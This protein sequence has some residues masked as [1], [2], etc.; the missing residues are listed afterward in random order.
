MAN[1]L[2]I[3]TR[4]INLN[5]T[6]AT[7]YT[8]RLGS[9][10]VR[11]VDG[12]RS[13]SPAVNN[14]KVFSS[15][16]TFPSYESVAPAYNSTG[17]YITT[18]SITFDRPLSINTT[19]YNVLL[20]KKGSGSDTLVATIASTDSRI[21]KNNKTI[22]I[23]LRNLLEGSS[24]YYLAADSGIFIDM[25]KFPTPA[26]TEAIFKYSTA[27]GPQRVRISPLNGTTGTFETTASI[28]FDRNMFF[29]TQDLTRNITVKTS[30]GTDFL[31]FYSTS[32]GVSIVNTSL[33][34][35][36]LSKPMPEGE[37]YINYSDKFVR[38]QY[39][40]PAT[41][42]SN[43]STFR[44]KQTSISNMTSRRY[45]ANVPYQ[46]F[47]ATTPQVLD[48]DLN[49]SK[50]YTFTLN[51]NSG[52]F[53]S[54]NGVIT[55]TT[56]VYQGTK[57]E[58]NSEIP[59]VRFTRSEVERNNDITFNYTLTK[60]GTLLVNNTYD[61]VGIP[62][63]LASPLTLTISQPRIIDETIT[64][65]ASVSTAT[66]LNGTVEFKSDGVVIATAPINIA[67]VAST[68][69]A[70]A[71]TGT[72]AIFASFIE[73]TTNDGNRYETL[74]SVTQQI[75]VD[76]GQRLSTGTLVLSSLGRITAG[77]NST[78]LNASL[79]TST[80]FTG[81][82]SG[83]VSI[84][85]S[86]FKSVTSEI[87]TAKVVDFAPSTGDGFNN[88]FQPG[89]IQLETL[90]GF[91]FEF[92]EYFTLWFDLAKLLSD[93]NLQPQ[94]TT[95][96]ANDM[97]IT[98]VDTVN[99]RLYLFESSESTY[100][101]SDI[102]DDI[103]ES[104]D[105]LNLTNADLSIYF[106]LLNRGSFWEADIDADKIE[107]T[108]SYA[109]SST[110]QTYSPARKLTTSTFV[111]NTATYSLGSFASGEY[112]FYADWEGR[113][114][115]P[116][117][118]GQTSTTITQIILPK[119]RV[120]SRIS[121]KT[122]TFT[123]YNVDRSINTC[124]VGV[125]VANWFN[126]S[127]P[128]GTITLNDGATQ[129][130]STSTFNKYENIRVTPTSRTTS[131]TGHY[132]LN[133]T[134]TA[135][136]ADVVFASGNSV[137]DGDALVSKLQL[138]VNGVAYTNT[139]S[140]GGS[141]TDIFYKVVNT[142]TSYWLEVWN[143]VAFTDN[144][145]PFNQRGDSGDRDISIFNQ[146]TSLSNVSVKVIK[147]VNT[148]WNTLVWNPSA[149]SGQL[150]SGARTLTMTYSGD[151]YNFSTSTTST[152][153]GVTK[154]TVSGAV[155]LQTGTQI[156][157]N[158][159]GAYPVNPVVLKSHP[160]FFYKNT[161]TTI[162]GWPLYNGGEN[163]EFGLFSGVGSLEDPISFPAT[164]IPIVGR[165]SSFPLP[166]VGTYTQVVAIIYYNTATSVNDLVFVKDP[167][168]GTQWEGGGTLSKWVNN[169]G[170]GTVI[171]SATATSTG[172][173]SFGS[174][175]STGL[176]SITI[177]ADQYMNTATIGKFLV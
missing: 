47:T 36:L 129:L 128:T 2:T 79:N 144:G 27:A 98:Q 41:G 82:E 18:A 60:D 51:S 135:S 150:D 115:A 111:N 40:F 156:S 77:N 175:S 25:F 16:S 133:F 126:E 55:G 54:T 171:T 83:R 155:V 6:T 37:Y 50:Q 164:S 174:T 176:H 131:P 97:V 59:N 4:L 102:L 23:D 13:P 49:S 57:Q 63:P 134:T 85:N 159:N 100:S 152:F 151:T 26:L 160:N 3:N 5:W 157:A 19:P 103:A 112:V 67:G 122:K 110:T 125:S 78:I 147:T 91:N 163:E 22:T 76:L 12:N 34:V 170:T 99:K 11:E 113:P 29:D 172:T 104:A 81:T 138:Y 105:N 70:I 145:Y 173:V 9:D 74:N 7:N 80:V 28:F 75:F 169:Y 65:T 123:Y 93:N 166:N 92:G 10:V 107:I 32:T 95:F 167:G 130:A 153:I 137:V 56:W 14:L 90:D 119:T 161:A 72:K 24:T 66:Q 146:W 43:S 149:I 101:Y 86:S 30:T 141:V 39:T 48:V 109:S 42:I 44:W 33:N 89:Y 46:L 61:L 15:F 136:L 71:S 117:Y 35:S 8:I 127:A 165:V 140:G 158:L 121:P 114:V 73:P 162:T 64:F 96:V 38:D 116:K 142:G 20:Y 58:I 177:S 21:V 168:F 84:A 1:T 31:K 106:K 87:V 45:K 17:S 118:Y 124:S 139:A 52:T 69:T 94:P 132:V 154:A 62:F 53:T 120:V 88:N 108:T 148:S 143:P 68:V